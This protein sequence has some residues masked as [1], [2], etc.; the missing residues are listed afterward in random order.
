MSI[1]TILL[2]FWLILVGVSWLTW[3]SIDPKF[4]GLLAFITGII[5]LIESARPLIV[6]K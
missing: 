5:F 3:I 2:A 4:L 6:K 1:S